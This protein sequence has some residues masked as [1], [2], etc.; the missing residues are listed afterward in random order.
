MQIINM[1]VDCA[2]LL[3]NQLNDILS[4]TDGVTLSEII[5]TAGDQSGRANKKPTD[6]IEV[7][8]KCNFVPL[9]G[10]DGND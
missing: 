6:E 4:G 8:V 9:V 1:T 5:I 10:G 3:R 7:G 2:V